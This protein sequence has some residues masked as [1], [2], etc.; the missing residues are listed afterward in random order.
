MHNLLQAFRGGVDTS[1][2]LGVH[3]GRYPAFGLQ[4]FSRYG[5]PWLLLLF[6]FVGIPGLYYANIIDIEQVNK[7][8]RFLCF[9]L[10]ALSL[11]LIWGYGG[12][13]CLC[14]FLFISLGG[15]AMG[16]FLAHHGDIEGVIDANNWGKIPACL[17]VVYPGQVG[18]T[19]AEWTVPLTWKP[20][21][22]IWWTLGLGMLIPGFVAG[23]IGFFMFRSRVRGVFFAIVT[24]AIVLAAWNVFTLNNM[25]FGGTN[26]VTDFNRIIL[27]SKEKIAIDVDPKKLKA[28][29]LTRDDVKRAL[30]EKQQQIAEAYKKQIDARQRIVKESKFVYGKVHVASTVSELSGPVDVVVTQ[31]DGSQNSAH[32]F[33]VALARSLHV[34]HARDEF[35][36]VELPKADGSRV[37][38]P[39][40]ADVDIDG[41]D[42]TDKNVKL[43]LYVVTFAALVVAFLLC[44]LLMKSRI[45][46]VLIAV[47]DN[48]NRLRFSGYEPY[49]F[50]TF[51][52]FLSGMIAGLAGILYAPQARIYTPQYLEPRWSIMVV[53][54]VAVGGRGTLSGPILGAL[55]VNYLYDYLTS[56]SPDT[57]PFVLGGL[58]IAVTLFLPD[59]LMGVWH[60]WLSL[61]VRPSI[62]LPVPATIP[63]RP[64]PSVDLSDQQKRWDGVVTACGVLTLLIGTY[65]AWTLFKYGGPFEY[66]VA[67]ES[68][69][70]VV[71][72]LMAQRS[73][74]G[75]VVGLLLVFMAFC[76][77][78]QV[79]AGIGM[80]LGKPW[81][82]QVV[83]RILTFQIALFIAVV[84]WGF[85][86][87][88]LH[89]GGRDFELTRR[90]D[91]EIRQVEL[92]KTGRGELQQ[93]EISWGAKAKLMAWGAVDWFGSGTDKL[94]DINAR[95]K[96]KRELGLLENAPWCA[97]FSVWALPV[98]FLIS[99]SSVKKL[100]DRIA[101]DETEED[102]SDSVGDEHV[103]DSVDE[104]AKVGEEEESGFRQRLSR[105]AVRGASVTTSKSLLDSPLMR[106][107]NIK[108]LFDGFKAL[109]IYDF[110]V[111]HYELNVIIGPNGAGKT[112]LCDVISGK[113]RV[114]EGRV[115]FAGE[116]ITGIPEVDI[117]RLGVGRKFQTPTVFESLTVYQNMELALPGRDRLIHNFGNR[118]TPE[119]RDQI[120]GMLNRV[121]LNSES[122]RQ[123]RYLS[124]GQRQWLEI[125]ML[126]LS[127]PRLLLVDEPAAGLTDEETA[128]TAELLL[129]LKDEH[130]VI[131][132]E[133]DMEFVRLLNSPVTVLNEGKIMAQGTMEEVQSNPE[134]IE[135]Y[136]GR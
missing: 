102:V 97:L 32:R 119:E 82:S 28:H 14:Q 89:F 41:F 126:I 26:G 80:L 130:S 116:D 94:V 25:K 30:V 43:A 107:E 124:H 113:T 24:Q 129:E 100:Y 75:V 48:E 64:A 16:M 106:V 19:E 1:T 4:L 105:I 58:F 123:V 35:R 122:D 108:V 96:E 128:L 40:V 20:F 67:G 37:R 132:I 69:P 10:A 79:P 12:M 78:M 47:R 18:Q 72:G 46:R 68:G 81:G 98:L 92:E 51:I 134:V 118:A 73:G 15:Y 86:I 29:G 52:F 59:G 33:S 84:A 85:Y 109:D 6:G 63:P 39:D 38:L 56:A 101:P 77:V 11:D 8:G 57:W 54:W 23:L 104:P 91:A 76:G 88:P 36:K 62:N 22:N 127:S 112:T 114:T 66:T 133:H 71:K 3:Y 9:A 65:V 55:G 110:R 17:F 7:L 125:S 74:S 87:R 50:K 93:G 95:G 121:R 115:Y 34:W 70:Q 49:V 111:P 42:L 45:G 136:L 13:L 60:K 5:L 90:A 103:P 21:W 131:V 83:A 53:I 117:A 120:S 44:R 61:R 2:A 31:D 27:S 99:R 135:A